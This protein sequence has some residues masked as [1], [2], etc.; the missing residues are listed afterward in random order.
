M[1]NFKTFL[2]IFI[3]FLIQTVILARV[4]IF[5]AVPSLVMA[6]VICVML[7][8]NEFRNA[9]T[10]S[11]ICSAAMGALG[12][13]EFA[14]TVLFYVYSSIIIFALRKKPAYVGNLPKAV[15][16]TFLAS[17]VMEILYF[18]IRTLS[19]NTGMLL[20]DALPTAIF[21]AVLALIVYPVL[22]VTMYR[23]EKKKK[24]LIA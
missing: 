12:G 23:E 9:V 8:E 14:V 3:V 15:V 6:Y 16:W 1:R 4:H 21:S 10:I 7:L 24:L 13:R 2:W 5:G 22:K 20:H 17:G 11:I 19:V 18:A